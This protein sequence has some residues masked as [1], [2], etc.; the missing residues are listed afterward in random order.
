MAGAKAR[1]LVR[2]K[3]QCLEPEMAGAAATV[4]GVLRGRMARGAVEAE[5]SGGEEEPRPMT[6][7]LWLRLRSG[8]DVGVGGGG[9]AGFH[10][11]KER[12]TYYHIWTH[13]PRFYSLTLWLEGSGHLLP[14]MDT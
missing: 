10:G 3:K 14:Y 9:L 7:H 5:L 2:E 8:E 12:V 1:D 11:L 4:H 13:N 6:Y